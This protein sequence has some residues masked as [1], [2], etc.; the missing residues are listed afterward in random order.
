MAR[1]PAIVAVLVC[2]SV[3]VEGIHTH[4]AT[5]APTSQLATRATIRKKISSVRTFVLKVEGLDATG[6][7][8]KGLQKSQFVL[9][10]LLRPL[11]WVTN[12][13][14]HGRKET[15][16]A[17]S[18]DTLIE[19]LTSSGGNWFTWCQRK[20]TGTMYFTATE[21][22]TLKDMKSK[23]AVMCG[24]Y[25]PHTLSAVCCFYSTKR[26]N[27][28]TGSVPGGPGSG[29]MEGSAYMCS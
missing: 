10:N 26:T 17:P 14:L 29:I 8:G 12:K 7:Q 23:H 28:S 3:L 5:T 16:P 9:G 13:A 11:I 18:V 20:D 19:S 25:M 15:V 21:A 2:A 6:C 4:T 27:G 24:E 1:L 22:G